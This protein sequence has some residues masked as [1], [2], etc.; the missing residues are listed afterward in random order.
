MRNHP[1]VRTF[2]F[3]GRLA[4]G[5]KED[6]Q[7]DIDRVIDEAVMARGEEEEICSFLRL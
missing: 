3:A 4:N 1:R 5:A 7:V 2:E 6:S